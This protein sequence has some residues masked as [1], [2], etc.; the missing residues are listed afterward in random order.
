MLNPDG[1]VKVYTPQRSWGERKRIMLDK[2]DNKKDNPV[3][4]MDNFCI[5]R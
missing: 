4:D 5:K 2:H 1:D 3:Q